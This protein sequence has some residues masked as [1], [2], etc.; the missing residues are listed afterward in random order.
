MEADAADKKRLWAVVLGL[1]PKLDGNQWCIL[2]GDDM[3]T[4]VVGFGSCPVD[5]IND[6]E[7]AMYAVGGKK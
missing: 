1:T 3:Q 7:K 6:F 4:G 5:A 2:W